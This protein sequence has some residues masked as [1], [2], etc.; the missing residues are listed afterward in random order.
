[1]FTKTVPQMQTI[2]NPAKVLFFAYQ[3]GALHIFESFASARNFSNK[4]KSKNTENKFHAQWMPTRTGT[5]VRF[6]QKLMI[7][8]V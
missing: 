1:M 7:F 5:N 4:M 6:S 8:N 2:C 3:T